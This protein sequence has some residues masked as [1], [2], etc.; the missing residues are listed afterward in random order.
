MSEDTTA[1]DK[2]KLAIAQTK[3]VEQQMLDVLVRIESLVREAFSLY[4]AQPKTEHP[5]VVIPAKSKRT[6][7]GD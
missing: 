2:V 1:V 5:A 3:T 7:H 6:K 4:A